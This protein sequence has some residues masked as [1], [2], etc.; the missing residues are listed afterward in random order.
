MKKR[1][2]AVLL[3]VALLC[4]MLT[5]GAAATVADQANTYQVGYAKLD[6]NPWILYPESALP[7]GV[8]NMTDENGNAIG[9]PYNA[10]WSASSY[11]DR[12]KTTT[13]DGKTVGVIANRL[14]GS[15]TATNNYAYNLL[16]DN[17]DGKIG[18]G[19]GL[20]VTAT[21]VTDSNGKTVVFLTIDS[22]GG[23]QVM[24]NNLKTSVVAGIQEAGGT[25][26]SNS[27][28][29]NGSHSHN[30]PDMENLSSTYSQNDRY[31][32]P[33]P[34]GAYWDYYRNRITAAAVAAYVSSTPATMSKGVIDASAS[35]GYQLNFVRHYTTTK[36]ENGV[37]LVGGS[38]FGPS[39]GSYKNPVSQ[40]DDRL[41]LLQFTPTDKKLEPIVLM[42]WRAHGTFIG[43]TAE[44]CY[45][46]DY[47]GPTRSYLARAGYRVAFFQGAAGNIVPESAISSQ[48]TWKTEKSTNFLSSS[49]AGVNYDGSKLDDIVDAAHYGFLLSKVAQN[50]L[51]SNMTELTEDPIRNITA[52]F[53]FDMQKDTA[54]QI[55]AARFWRAKVDAYMASHP[56]VSRGDAS[57]ALGYTTSLGKPHTINGVLFN[58]YYHLD[59]VYTRSQNS[60]STGTIKVGAIMLGDQV[61]MVTCGN[62]LFDRYSN[63]HTVS[64][65]SD[66]D[67]NDLVDEVYGTPFVL[68]YTNG[69]HAY[70]SNSLAYT[71]NEGASTYTAGSYEANTSKFNKGTGE[72]LIVKYRQMLDQ[73]S[74]GSFCPACQEDVSWRPLDKT[75]YIS[76]I[77]NQRDSDNAIKKGYWNGHFVLTEDVSYAATNTIMPQSGDKMCLDLNGHTVSYEGR[78]AYIAADSTLSIMDKSAA[79]T[80]KMVSY[81]HGN[82]YS[83]GNI[84]AGGTFNLYSGTLQ[85]VQTDL[86]TATPIGRG[87]VVNLPTED[88][89]FNMYGG[90]LIGCDLKMRGNGTEGDGCG[91]T[92][93]SKG[94]LNLLGGEIV[95]GKA[96]TGCY[97]DCI[98]VAAGKVTLSG[99]AKV[100]EIC[101]LTV[102]SA[103]LDVSGSYTGSASLNYISGGA[104]G[105]IVGMG[106]NNCDISQAAINCV[107]YPQTVLKKNVSNQLYFGYLDAV[108]ANGNL[109]YNTLREA[110]QDASEGDLIKLINPV[111]GEGSLTV[112]KNIT[113]DFNGCDIDSAITVTAGKTLYCMDSQTADYTVADGVYTKIP[114]NGISGN[115]QAVPLGSAFAPEGCQYLKVV[116]NDQIS[117]HCVNLNTYSMTLR[118][119]RCGVY[120]TSAFAGDEVVSQQVASYGVALSVTVPPRV[121]NLD[122]ECRMSSFT[123][124]AGGAAGNSGSGTL[125]TNILTQD[126]T[127]AQNA[128]N[129][130]TP[131]YGRA[132]LLTKD[133]E[134]LLGNPVTRTLKEQV[135]AVDKNW[136]SYTQ[137]EKDGVAGMLLP[138]DS[139]VENWNI[140][141]IRNHKRDDGSLNILLIGSSHGLDSTRILYEVFQAEGLPKGT[142]NLTIA[143]LYYSGCTMQQHA[144]FLTNNK[145]VY[146]YHKVSTESNGKWT[147]QK[148]ATGLTAMQDKQW[149]IVIL[150]QAN[151]W[152][153][154]PEKYNANQ[155]SAVMNFVKANQA[156]T[157]EF[158]WNM[159]W[160]CPDDY[161]MFLNDDARYAIHYITKDV[162]DTVDFRTYNETYFSDNS[163]VYQQEILYTKITENVNSYRDYIDTDKVCP[164]GTAILKAQKLLQE[165][166]LTDQQA[167]LRVYRDYTHLSHY[168]RLIAAY[169]W[170]GTLMGKTE[171]KA[172]DIIRVIP[173]HLNNNEY[174]DHNST[175]NTSN[176]YPTL[177]NN[178]YTF[179]DQDVE[180]L[181]EAVNWALVH[182]YTVEN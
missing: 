64:N 72:K 22:I 129:A 162:N 25:I 87:G 57:K 144:D 42:N 92:V 95:S 123:D 94:T 14:A 8:S 9:V 32:T 147:R 172:E 158:A 41:F 34:V 79:Q 52:D 171:F 159:L 5:V 85:S 177:K 148:G 39:S 170:Y 155:L 15:G 125:L 127:D 134:Y 29:L 137:E 70:M 180:V 80:G 174:D 143:N 61:A 156:V 102:N 82:N 133:G 101:Y 164:A 178:V 161:E 10:A 46:S 97:G 96:A 168:G 84:Y 120:Y 166:G 141:N 56:G 48:N 153:G 107:N 12:V 76:M 24:L 54:E 145:A 126:N 3:V 138:Y 78:C 149:D 23:Y 30:A 45:S 66:N 1:L 140:P 179:T 86:D 67:W 160:A 163:G 20:Q 59:N 4:S 104:L 49:V 43:N 115:V 173:K 55:D 69:S 75:D 11:A 169:T 63:N 116:K 90:K 40:A 117:F 37:T 103:Q 135:E 36:K 21:S 89:V 88:S 113:L 68:A 60:V 108:A 44:K 81:T 128:D 47:I 112:N 165:E 33:T 175:Y 17:A 35:C 93:W 110:I 38:N 181:V 19:D 122:K 114:A 77:T 130:T 51:N 111:S 150:Q 131:I 62:E 65:T 142:E 18:Y 71:Y 31:G 119:D 26:D 100:D 146:E 157:P 7:K 121:D 73:L 105:D 109:R 176:S 27:I 91:G 139:V 182:P 106:I 13:A 74:G 6:V 2:L 132:Y 152:S 98:Y 28:Y 53:S 99:N 50:C 154:I 167:Q 124:F 83:G 118:A 58:S 136:G 16:D 151:R